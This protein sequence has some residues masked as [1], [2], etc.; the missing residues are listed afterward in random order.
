MTRAEAIR[1]AGA[2]LARARAERDALPPRQAA[3]LAHYSGGPSIED[4]ERRI[5]L[6]R[7]LPVAA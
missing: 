2:V 5:R 1:A 3:E 7:G 4:I 6:M